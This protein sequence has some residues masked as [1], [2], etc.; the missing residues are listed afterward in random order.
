MTVQAPLAEQLFSSQ[1]LSQ[2]ERQSFISKRTFLGRVKGERKSP[3]KGISP[4]F[5]DYRPYEIGD[6]LRYVDWNVFGRLDRLYLK[7]F[8]DEEDL[9]IHLLLD[10]SGSMDFGS[11]S[12]FQYGLRLVAALAFVG[13]VDLE[14]VGVGI[15]RNRVVE[16]WSPTR[17]RKQFLPLVEFLGGVRPGGVTDLDGA[18]RDY[19]LRARDPGLTV[20]VSD[21]MDPAGF[22]TGVRA[23][24]ERHFDLHVIQILSPEEMDPAYGGDLRLVDA[25]SGETREV[26]LDGET[27]RAYRR[28]LRE[29]TTHCETTCRTNKIIYHR[30][31]TSE[32]MEDLIL[33]R[34]KGTLLQ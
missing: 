13:L 23:F 2:L 3:R 15:V 11:P 22:A 21:L 34:L 30:A 4:E 29:F 20:I 9:R 10:A 33:R 25:E 16:G 17:G 14:R 1:F 5:Y 19:A 31:I 27:L 28:R 24:L 12:K 7:L 8:V 26:T 6:D 18:L 32:P